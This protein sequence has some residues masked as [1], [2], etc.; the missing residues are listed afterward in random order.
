[1]TKKG[2]I[3]VFEDG[4]KDW[5]GQMRT[6]ECDICHRELT[7]N[8]GFVVTYGKIYCMECLNKGENHGEE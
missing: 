6:L 5:I 8:D 3:L 1:M 2:Y 4:K 7:K